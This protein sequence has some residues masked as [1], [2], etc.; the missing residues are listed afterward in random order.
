MDQELANG[1][2]YEPGRRCVSTHQVA[3]LFASNDVIAAILEM[4]EIR[5]RQLMRIY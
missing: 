4:A 3:T 1:V 2:E 5:L